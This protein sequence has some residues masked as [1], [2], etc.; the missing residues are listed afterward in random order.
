MGLGSAMAG[1]NPILERQKDDFYPTP[2]EVTVALLEVETFVGSI[3]EPACGDGTMARLLAT[4]GNK[5]AGSDL[6]P[7]GY[8]TKADFLAIRPRPMQ[9]TSI[10]TN[11][12]FGKVA[13]QFIE[14]GLAFQ[15]RKMALILK[16]SYWHADTRH[17]LYERCQP[18]RIYKLTW[19]PD[20]LGLG[21]PTMEVMWCVW[22]RDHVGET[23]HHLLRRPSKSALQ[24][25]ISLL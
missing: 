4:K 5:V 15:P 12:P 8:G 25:A 2:P 6:N 18:A 17:D 11:P 10:V 1:G 13:Q 23:T 16:S 21:R 22:D 19:R 3:W 24:A 7:R 20:F 14:H 9:N